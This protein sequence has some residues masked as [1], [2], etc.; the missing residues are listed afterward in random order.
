MNPVIQKVKT[1]ENNNNN[2]ILF[3]KTML[4]YKL[5]ND[6]ELCKLYIVLTGR[7]LCVRRCRTFQVI[8]VYCI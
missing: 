7:E 3:L 1:K 5:Y 2:Y 8:I 6:L 4:F